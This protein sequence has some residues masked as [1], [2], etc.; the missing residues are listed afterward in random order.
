M[1][2]TYTSTQDVRCENA[3]ARGKYSG[4]YKL[5]VTE[6]LQQKEEEEEL[7]VKQLLQLKY[8]VPQ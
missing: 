1:L 4:Q 2:H 5:T 6:V 3:D 8:N 7:Q